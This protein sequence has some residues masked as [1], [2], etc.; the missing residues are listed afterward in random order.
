MIIHGEMHQTAAKLKQGLPRI[1]AAPEVKPSVPVMWRMI[2]LSSPFSLVSVG[3]GIRG[4]GFLAGGMQRPGHLPKV[5]EHILKIPAVV[6]GDVH[7]ERCQNRWDFC[8][9]SC[10]T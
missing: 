2:R 1:A 8:R 3:M 10:S 4:R 7:G 9:S 5:E 6:L